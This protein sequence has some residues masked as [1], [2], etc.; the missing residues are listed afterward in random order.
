MIEGINHIAIAVSDIERAIELFAGVFGLEVAHREYIESFG[1]ETA[2]FRIGGTEIELVEG[3]TDESAISK[4]VEKNGP[5]IHHI[6]F[7]VGDIEKAVDTLTAN[8]VRMI[9]ETPR[10]G[11]EGSRVSF[12]HPSATMGILFELVERATRDRS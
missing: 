10:P 8:S 9:D 3:K 7:E 11:K 5:G 1:V 2:T 4:Y 12:I 6:A